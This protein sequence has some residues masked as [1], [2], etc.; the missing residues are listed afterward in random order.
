MNWYAAIFDIL[1]LNAD[2]IYS[3]FLR[4]VLIFSD[5]KPT[6]APFVYSG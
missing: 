2:W 5:I 6:T 4:G 1:Y 3:M